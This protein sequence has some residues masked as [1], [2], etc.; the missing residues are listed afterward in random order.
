MDYEEGTGPCPDAWTFETDYQAS[1]LDEGMS[2]EFSNT[3]DREVS[4]QGL[5]NVP[6][7]VGGENARH[8]S[9]FFYIQYQGST[10]LYM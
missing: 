10:I 3:G 9:H 2:V 1:N 4:I 5:T 6:N 7:I 8:L